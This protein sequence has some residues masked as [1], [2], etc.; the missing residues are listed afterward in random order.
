[1]KP[2]SLFVFYFSKSIFVTFLYNLSDIFASDRNISTFCCKTIAQHASVSSERTNIHSQVNTKQLLSLFLEDFA[3][4]FKCPTVL[5]HITT[6]SFY[7]RILGKIKMTF[8]PSCVQSTLPN[9]HSQNV[10]KSDNPEIICGRAP[11]KYRHSRKRP[12]LQRDKRGKT[13]HVGMDQLCGFNWQKKGTNSTE[14]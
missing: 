14:T 2:V 1:M 10:L 4:A 11:V 12:I 8:C 5:K 3:A 13:E 7:Q 9:I 6:W